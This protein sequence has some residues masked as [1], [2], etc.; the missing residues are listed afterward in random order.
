M[1][2]HGFPILSLMILLPLAGSAVILLAGARRASLFALAAATATFL[3]TLIPLGFFRNGESGFLFV[4]HRPWIDALG[5]SYHVGVDGLSLF[6]LPLTGFLSVVAVLVSWN[7]VKIRV[8]AYFVSLLVLEAGM[9]GVF[10]ALD[11]ILF[12]VFWEAMLIPMFL[13]IGV[14][15][16]GNRRYAAVKFILYTVAGS[17]FL[18]VG[19]I[20]M[21]FLSASQGTGFTFDLTRWFLFPVPED[22]QTGLFLLFFIAF[23]VKVPLIPFHTWLPDAHVEAPTAG[24][25]ILAG[26]LLKMGVYGI[27]RFCFPLFPGAVALFT[28]AVMALGII[29]V[30]YGALVAFAQEDLKKLVAYSSVSHMGLIVV[31]IF[32]MNPAGLKGG[33]IQMLN[34]GLSTGALF[35]LVGAIYERKKTRNLKELGGLARS[36]PVLA[37]FFVLTMLSS[38]GLPGLNGFVGEFLLLLGTFQ[39]RWWLGALAATSVILGAVYLLWMTQR[40]LFE[41]DRSPGTDP[42]ADFGFRERFVMTSMVLLMLFIGLFP[43]GLTDR[44]EPAARRLMTF[45]VSR[46]APAALS[47]A[48]ETI[49]IEETIHEQDGFAKSPFAAL[50]FIPRHGDAPLRTSCS[51]GFGQPA[52]GSFYETVGK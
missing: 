16:G 44:L 38:V 51:S 37:L 50:P 7:S 15:G 9:L 31:G 3:V 21:A 27:L 26:V 49:P 22:G 34:H 28:P 39:F 5:I 18:L 46:Q 24:S 41:K 40:V 8:K 23:A 45:T 6:L 52:L 33:I 43:S 32:A 48:G 12:Y 19:F 36:T 20:L 47:A 13:I 17:L 29:G 10:V 4:E 35:V 1:A 25:V 2:G 14:W 30:I 11:A 42:G